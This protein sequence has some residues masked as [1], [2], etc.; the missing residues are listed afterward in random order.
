MRSRLRS[1]RYMAQDFVEAFISL[2]T[3]VAARHK[4]IFDR[5]WLLGSDSSLLEDVGL[6]LPVPSMGANSLASSS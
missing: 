4:F 6:S 2:V 1:R 5:Q 3:F